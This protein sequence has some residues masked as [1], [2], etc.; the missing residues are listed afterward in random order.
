MQFEGET[1]PDPNPAHFLALRAWRLLSN[2][3]GGLDWAG[4]PIVAASLGID[5]PQ[6][7]IDRLLVIRS[8]RPDDNDDTE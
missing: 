2:G 1:P 8:Y 4:L 3:M 6:K 5:D 7:L